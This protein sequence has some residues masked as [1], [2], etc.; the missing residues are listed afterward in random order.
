[1][2]FQRVFHFCGA[3]LK[4]IDQISMAAVK[5]VEHLAQLLRGS[6]GIEPDDPANDM[7]GSNLIGGVEVAGFSCRFERSDDDPCRIRPQI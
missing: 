6:F 3:R 1:M 2:W 7:I 5:I 4:N